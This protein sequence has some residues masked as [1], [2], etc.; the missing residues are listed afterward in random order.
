MQKI[1]IFLLRIFA[2]GAVL[3]AMYYLG[4]Y[5]SVVVP[6]AVISCIALICDAISR[7]FDDL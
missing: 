2:L 5:I 6:L 4:V 7:S 1:D 3:G